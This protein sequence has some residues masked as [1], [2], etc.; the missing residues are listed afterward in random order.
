[1]ELEEAWEP[2]SGLLS[3]WELEWELVLGLE[4]VLG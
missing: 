3:E 1:L 4:W 2:E